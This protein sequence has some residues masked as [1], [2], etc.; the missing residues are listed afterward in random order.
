MILPC[1]LLFL[2]VI[3]VLYL[4]ALNIWQ[5][6]ENTPHVMYTSYILYVYIYPY[7]RYVLGQLKHRNVSVGPADVRREL[8]QL[9][10]Q[11]LIY[12]GATEDQFNAI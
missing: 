1:I 5:V 8:S 7:V 9:E 12:S 11:G 3:H 4:N 6:Y 10:A 2:Y